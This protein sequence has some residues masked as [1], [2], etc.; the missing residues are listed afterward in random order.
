MLFTTAMAWGYVKYLSKGVLIHTGKF[1]HNY[2]FRIGLGTRIALEWQ[3]F[4]EDNRKTNSANLAN[5][6]EMNSAIQ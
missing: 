4:V 2:R 1:A 6:I 3:I 5:P